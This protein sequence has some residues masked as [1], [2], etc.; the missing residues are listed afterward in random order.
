ML[1]NKIFIKF[2]KKLN[3]VF[4]YKNS[5]NNKKNLNNHNECC[6][7]IDK[8]CLEL[9][10]YLKI[11]LTRSLTYNIPHEVTIIVPRAEIRKE[12]IYPD[13]EKEVSE[14]IL[15]SI[16]VVHSPQRPSNSESRSSIIPINSSKRTS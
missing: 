11:G 16:T 9:D 1:L 14:I 4:F 2:I 12:N 3:T 10:E 7:N 6:K 13:G 5:F 15:N 8:V